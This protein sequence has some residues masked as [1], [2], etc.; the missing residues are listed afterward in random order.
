MPSFYFKQLCMAQNKKNRQLFG[1]LHFFGASSGVRP[2]AA[3]RLRASFCSSPHSRCKTTA[4]SPLHR[5]SSLTAVPSRVRTPS[6]ESKNKSGQPYN[7]PDFLVHLQG[8]EP[9]TPWLRVRCSASWAKDANLFGTFD[10]LTF[11]SEYV[12]K[13]IVFLK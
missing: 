12:N 10:I 7:C 6:L 13:K 4:C 2:P 8:F 11:L 1:C 9:W 5:S 3:L